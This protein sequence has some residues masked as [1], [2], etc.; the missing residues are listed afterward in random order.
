MSPATL[1]FCSCTWILPLTSRRCF[2]VVVPIALP[3]LMSWVPADIATPTVTLQEYLSLLQVLTLLL[4]V[5]FELPILMW[6]VV[7]AGLVEVATL[8]ASRRVS[9]LV[10][11][12]AAAMLTPPDVVTQLLVVAPMIVLYEIGLILARR[13]EKARERAAL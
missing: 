12:M 9:I 2:G 11:L 10:M 13:A 3:V 4:G 6:L 8:S 5:V 1:L 7:R